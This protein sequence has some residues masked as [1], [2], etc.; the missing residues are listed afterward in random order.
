M[1]AKIGRDG[2]V[3]FWCPGCDNVHRCKGWQFN[4]DFEKPTL[5][6]SVMVTYTPGD[7]DEPVQRCHSFVR[8][9]V[10]Q[11][12]GDS[13]HTLAGKTIPLPPWEKDEYL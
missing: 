7:P 6:P 9:G 12:L 8:D 3:C 10:I 4:G 5:S 13:T 1:K 2:A 11:F